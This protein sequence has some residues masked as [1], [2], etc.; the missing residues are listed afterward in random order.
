MRLIPVGH[1]RLPSMQRHPSRTLAVRELGE[2]T[3]DELPVAPRGSAGRDRRKAGRRPRPPKRYRIG[4]IVAYSGLSRQTVHNYTTMGLLREVEWTR[5]GHRLY[6]ES[7]F[8]RLDEIAE[9]KAGGMSL[10]RIREH[11][12]E[13]DGPSA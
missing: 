8:E 10:R 12:E 5:G 2:C 3:L 6:D 7:V 13:M 4:E 1:G 11:F 9:M